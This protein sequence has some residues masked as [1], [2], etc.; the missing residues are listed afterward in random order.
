MEEELKKKIID[1]L[2]TKGL[3]NTEKWDVPSNVIHGC[4]LSLS[5]RDVV[6]YEKVE[7]SVVEL[8]QE[9]REV[10]HDGSQEHAFFRKIPAEGMLISE[11]EP[12]RVGRAFAFKK[13]WVK[14]D[15]DK[16]FRAQDNVS[17]DVCAMLQN[18]KSI[19]ENDVDMLKKRNLVVVKKMQYYLIREGSKFGTED[20]H[21][22]TEVTAQMVLEDKQ[23]DL[24]PFNFHTDGLVL[25]CG[26]LHPLAKLRDDLKI[27]F[28]GLGFMEMSTS[29]YIDA[30]FWNFDALFLSQHHPAR[31]PEDTFYLESDVLPD[32]PEKYF[33]DVQ[34]IHEDG[35]FGS[36]GYKSAWKPGEAKKLMLRTHTTSESARQ[37]YKMAQQP[38]CPAKLFSIDRV[39]R[40]E[41][42]DATH[43]A[44]FHQIEGLIVDKNLKL[45]HLMGIL[46][47][48]YRKLGLGKIKFKPAYNPYTEP[49]MEVF[50][51]H[52]GLRRWMEVGNSGIFRPEMLRTMGFDEDVSVIAWG[53]SLERP[54]MIRYKLNNIRDLLGHKVDIEFVKRCGINAFDE[55][56]AFS[57]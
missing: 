33:K 34:K 26:G 37:L 17:D 5:S 43:L 54:A 1:E 56:T 32:L 21:L 47:E 4:I 44:E 3:V 16:I 6:E 40:N 48:F 53:L 30:A 10:A 13:N 38:F 20:K 11:C 2:G 19:G 49:S 14:K 15:G 27:I 23:V 55:K 36:T 42:V 51:Y 22:T 31:D 12:F 9:G 28:L 50:A 25:P 29:N 7:K 41:S 18:L 46:E 24:K 52:E 45:S 8:T 35:G 57:S 39:F